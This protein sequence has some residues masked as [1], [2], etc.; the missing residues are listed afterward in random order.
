MMSRGIS[1]ND[2]IKLYIKGLLLMNSKYD[3]DIRS[4]IFNVIDMYWR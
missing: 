3:Y 2:S 1:Y 4:K